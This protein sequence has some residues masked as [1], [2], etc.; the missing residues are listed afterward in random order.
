[1]P[2]VVN[3]PHLGGHEIFLPCRSIRWM[4]LRGRCRP[5]SPVRDFDSQMRRFGLDVR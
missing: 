4:H 3:A 1:M 5:E 2:Q